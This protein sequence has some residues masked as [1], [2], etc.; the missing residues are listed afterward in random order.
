MLLDLSYNMLLP[1]HMILHTKQ[2]S[3][4]VLHD[5]FLAHTD[6]AAKDT[7]NDHMYRARLWMTRRM[8]LMDPVSH[9]H[10]YY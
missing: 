9:F 8:Y 1:V 10:Y 3:E 2:M 5:S 6:T 7:V 4:C